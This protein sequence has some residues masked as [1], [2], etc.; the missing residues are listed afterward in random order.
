MLGVAEHFAARGQKNVALCERGITA[1]HTHQV[2]SRSIMD[3]QAIPALNEFAP[4][5]PVVADPSKSTFRREYVPAMTR[6]A[7]A[8]GA[9]GIIVEIHG[10]PEKA[11]TDP[12]NALTFQGFDKLMNEVRAMEKIVRQEQ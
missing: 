1:P 6:A 11:W 4:T 10:Q 8:A 12:L 3:V 5:Y 9:D 2:N 7:V